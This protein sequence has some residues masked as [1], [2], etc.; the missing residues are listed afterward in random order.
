MEV[1][2]SQEKIKDGRTVRQLLIDTYAENEKKQHNEDSQPL[3]I[4]EEEKRSVRDMKKGAKFP[5]PFYQQTVVL[6]K[7]TF[8]QRRGEILSWDRIFQIAFIAVL[9]GLLWFRRDT[10]GKQST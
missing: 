4:N 2:S 6:A 7:R 3:E 10:V 9:A 8:T 5:T 1:V